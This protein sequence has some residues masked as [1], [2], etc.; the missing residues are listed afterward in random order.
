M[1][2]FATGTPVTTRRIVAMWWP[3]A[4][5]WLLMGLE[6]P[7][8]SA[9]MARLPN[10]EASLAAYGG[11]V[12]P[13]ALIIEAP[14]IMLLAASTALSRDWASYVLIRRVMT[15][16]GAALTLLHALIAFTP[17]FDVVVTGWMGAPEPIREPAR[18]GLM[19][20]T[21]WTW[22]IA[23]RR[24]QQGV[25][26]RYG[27]SR[28]VMV[29]TMVRLGVNVAVLTV[30][31]VWGRF[32]GIVVG[33]AAVSLG[34]L[35]EAVVIG[36]WVRPVVRD[37]LRP[38]P[39]LEDV[40]TLRKFLVFYTP[41][42][43]TSLIALTTMPLVSAAIARMP[44]A[45]SSM[46]VIPVLHGL[47]FLLRSLGFSFNEV[48]VALLDEP[49]A[50]HP[51]RRFATGLAGFNSAV[52]LLLAA[53]PLGWIYFAVV[54]SLD[55]SLVT[56]GRTALWIVVPM[57]ALAVIQHFLQGVLVHARR[58]VPI[59]ESVMVSFAGI[60]AGLVAGVIH[61]GITGLYVGM[62]A[63]VFGNLLGVA[64]LF[65]RSRSSRHAL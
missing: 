16:A 33:T 11:V 19:I 51:L 23:Y 60:V 45:V 38:A 8:V 34:V 28:A 44:L 53:T 13:L 3:L 56:L 7:A 9:I 14:I 35:A 58:T 48:V 1:T 41:L 21:P 46:A 52:L 6:L 5:S 54:A 65:Q 2:Q 57:P 4:G 31:Y 27:Q 22:S 15:L 61:G 29:G 20:M 36:L 50:Y 63:Y 32:E 40:L 39:P 12:F 49:G 25:L 30:G 43:L 42:A 17:L 10:P 64:W 62:G 47:T 37:S 59:T 24:F 26:I 18:L 55:E